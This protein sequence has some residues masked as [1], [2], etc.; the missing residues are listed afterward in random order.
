MS[1]MVIYQ[2]R[3]DHARDVTNFLHDFERRTHQKLEEVDPESRKGAEVCSLYDVVEYPTV[4]A[5]A[6]DGQVRNMWRGIPLPL[7]DEVSYY[8]E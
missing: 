8:V 3:S 7:I 5:T 2:S 4:I 1:I 6:E